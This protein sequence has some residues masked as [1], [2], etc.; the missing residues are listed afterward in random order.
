MLL[1]P[2]FKVTR[3]WIG[4]VQSATGR[5]TDILFLY[6]LDAKRST[7]ATGAIPSENLPFRLHDVPDPKPRR[8]IDH[9]A[10][11][12]SF[13]TEA[14]RA[15]HSSLA[16]VVANIKRMVLGQWKFEEHETLVKLSLYDNEHVLQTFRVTIHA[17]P[18]FRISTFGRNLIASHP[19]YTQNQQ[20]SLFP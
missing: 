19:L 2:K 15:R 8:E 13:E 16:S 1:F 6:I 18:K 5:S 4:I 7:L 9:V 3:P 11:N 10:V 12:S 20:S 14:K 17:S